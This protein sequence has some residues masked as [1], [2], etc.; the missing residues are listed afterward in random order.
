MSS[1]ILILFS[2][3]FS[4]Y[5][6]KQKLQKA[7]EKKT[8]KLDDPNW[9]MD[10]HLEIPFPPK[11]RKLIV[12]PTSN[13]GIFAKKIFEAFQDTLEMEEDDKLKALISHKWKTIFLNRFIRQHASF[14]NLA[15]YNDNVNVLPQAEAAALQ[16]YYCQ[17]ST[18]VMDITR[19]R[20]KYKGYDIIVPFLTVDHAFTI[21]LKPDE[22]PYGYN[23]ELFNFSGL[24]SISLTTI[25]FNFSL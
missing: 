23:D 15:L 8:M 4:F 7:L 24:V 21:R 16:R 1:Y 18:A 13:I 10:D 17:V 9:P 5:P 6:D 25:Y 12:E 19:L 11:L 14:K 22:Q 2:F 3:L 20:A